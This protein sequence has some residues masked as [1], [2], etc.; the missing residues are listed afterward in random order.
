MSL[1]DQLAEAPAV[2][3]RVL[4]LAV[5]GRIPADRGHSGR[6]AIYALAIANEMRSIDRDPNLRY[7]IA[8]ASL[9]HDIGKGALP[10]AALGD[11]DRLGEQERSEYMK[12]PVIGA[13]I[14]RACRE[15][16][17]TI[18]GILYHHERF[19]GTGFP[20]G[21]EGERIPLVA[22][23]VAAADAVDRLMWTGN[24]AKVLDSNS[25]IERIQQEAGKRYDPEVV[26]AL[27]SAWKKGMFENIYLATPV[28]L[29]EEFVEINK[30]AEKFAYLL[31]HLPS[32]PI[33]L[34]K[35]LK[36]MEEGEKSLTDIAN[37]ISNDQTLAAKVLRIVNS[38][39]Y[40]LSSRISTLPVALTILGTQAIKS[41]VL[42]LSYQDFMKKVA[43]SLPC[44]ESLWDHALNAAAW[45]RELARSNFEV[46][47]EEAFTAG[48]IHDIGRV[49]ALKQS[50][51][52]YC[53]LVEMASGDARAY[54]ALEE[55]LVGL[56][57]TQLGSWIAY[58][59]RLPASLV[60]AIRWHHEPQKS[61]VAGE[62]V[63]GIVSTVH[64]ADVLATSWTCDGKLLAK[65]FREAV[66]PWVVKEL[67]ER[68]FR[69]PDAI[70]LEQAAE[71]VCERVQE[72]KKLL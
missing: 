67:V 30:R 32:M 42:N 33:V 44:F 62:E 64:V 41:H 13:E 34:M 52:D 20:I 14:V 15:L 36:E 16:A 57:H 48:L 5:E 56:D 4:S 61:V 27:V 1:I 55:E 54:C 6:V 2:T 7:T 68:K 28:D 23:I 50:P 63:R 11:P 9:L 65:A 69:I 21:L 45:S 66:S 35:A 59:W 43:G 10:D 37:I 72:I 24:N 22:R 40:G 29:S 18:P 38:A 3:A 19:D 46:D 60:S 51:E 70:D 8:L 25:A 17:S 26:D 47:E 31:E 53:K 39:Y 12:H 49:A 71:R 58:T